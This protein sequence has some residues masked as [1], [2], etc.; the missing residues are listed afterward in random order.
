MAWTVKDKLLS[1]IRLVENVQ[2]I[3]A[4]CSLGSQ[5]IQAPTIC[6]LSTHL[7]S[8]SPR[9]IAIAYRHIGL[10][11]K[12]LKLTIHT[13]VK[14]FKKIILTIHVW[15]VGF[16]YWF[17]NPFKPSKQV[18]YEIFIFRRSPMAWHLIGIAVH[19]SQVFLVYPFRLFF[20][21][22]KY[23]LICVSRRMI[24]PGEAK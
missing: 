13:K 16:C 24:M 14:K 17:I 9:C 5:I 6:T 22:V 15:G 19:T 8:L 11:D 3:G 20:F 18:F 21:S 1:L 10:Y 2:H 7:H 12:S 23:F 4:I